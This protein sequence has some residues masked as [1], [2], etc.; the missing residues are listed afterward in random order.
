MA[1]KVS[2][3][4]ILCFFLSCLC[5]LSIW[6]YICPSWIV[7]SQLRSHI[8]IF[9]ELQNTCIIIEL[10][11]PCK[12]NMEVLHYKKYE[13]YEPLSTSIIS[14]GWSVYFFSTEVGTRGY[15][16]TTVKAYLSGVG[17]IGQLLKSTIKFVLSS[18]KASFQIWFSGACKMCIEE[19]VIIFP[20]KTVSDVATLSCSGQRHQKARSELLKTACL[21]TKVLTTNILLFRF[22]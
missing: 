16:S 14:S 6:L 22:L 8:F 17:F 20:I 4:D 2:I 7:I 9:S 21:A 5:F 15:C 3:L 11:Y 19:K 10:T 18:I 13:K 1:T 12:E